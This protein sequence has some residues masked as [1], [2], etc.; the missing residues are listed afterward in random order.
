MVNKIYVKIALSSEGESPKR[1]VERMRGVD[2]LPLVGD[3]DFEVKLNADER[4]FDKL[5]AIHRALK[6]SRV[7]YT[8]TTLADVSKPPEEGNAS[9]SVAPLLDMKPPEMKKAFYRAKIDRWREMGLD[10]T[11]LERHLENDL[12]SFKEVSKEFL[13]THLSNAPLVRDRHPPETQLDGEVLALLVETGKTIDELAKAT[14]RSEEQVTISL[15]RLISSGS[16]ERSENGK[17]EKYCLVPPPAPPPMKK[18][19][20]LPA[21]NREEAEDRIYNAIAPSGSSKEQI[22]RATRLPENQAT[23]ALASLSKKGR[24]RVI[25]KGKE[26]KF[27][28]N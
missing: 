24:I 7:R 9:R 16:A 28:P 17:H 3:Y 21:D 4:L 22:L 11:E 14:G 25:G 26:A 27:L 6:G 8:V 5:D 13:R 12:E 1:L 18:L 15:G 23:K 19:R 2:A 10:V 20:I